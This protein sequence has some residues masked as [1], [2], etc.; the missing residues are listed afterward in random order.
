MENRNEQ[1]LVIQGLSI[2]N[3]ANH[4]IADVIAERSSKMLEQALS[5]NFETILL[6][7]MSAAMQ[8]TL[9][10]HTEHIQ[11]YAKKFLGSSKTHLAQNLVD[12]QHKYPLSGL[13]KNLNQNELDSFDTD[14]LPEVN[15]LADEAGSI[16]IEANTDSVIGF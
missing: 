6:Q 8:E 13:Q 12:T 5:D 9:N 4:Q 14:L 2:G 15:R 7:K 10:L 3:N 11:A 16:T 1:D